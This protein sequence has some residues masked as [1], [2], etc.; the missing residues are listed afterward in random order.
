MR[1]PYRPYRPHESKSARLTREIIGRCAIGI[2]GLAF[3][4][5]GY[6]CIRTSLAIQRDYDQRAEARISGT[7][8]SGAGAPLAL[9]GVLLLIGSPLLLAALVPVATMEKLLGRQTNNTLWERPDAGTS[10]R[11]LDGLL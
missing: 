5:G 8:S 10:L 11:N 6:K 2:L 7:R 4:L 9:G 1:S 3:I